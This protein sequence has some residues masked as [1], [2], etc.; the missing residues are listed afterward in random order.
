MIHKIAP[1]PLTVIVLSVALWVSTAP[2]EAVTSRQ[3]TA[4]YKAMI[5]E[6]ERNRQSAIAEINRQLQDAAGQQRQSLE[7]M[8][9]QAW[10]DEERQRVTAG[11]IR[12]DCEKAAKV[13]G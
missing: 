8:L 5:A 4:D 3:C 9:E 11:M 13:N 7:A 2:S 6:I 12:R 1:L 10:D